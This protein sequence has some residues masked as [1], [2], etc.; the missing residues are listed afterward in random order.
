VR[1][2]LHFFAG[3]SL[4]LAAGWAVFPHVLYRVEPQPFE[5][6]HKIH[7]D[8]AGMAC[9]DC[10][11]FEAGGQFAG[12]PKLASC[13]TCHGGMQGKSAA[14]KTLVEQYVQPGREIPWRVYSRQPE[15]VR[16]SHIIHTQRAHLDCSRCHGT[17]GKTER[18][19]VY[20]ENRIT[21]ESR[22]MEMSACEDCHA[23]QR[24]NAGCLGCHR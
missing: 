12:I 23:K 17:Q 11:S 14:E 13:A 18:L 9:K 10:H 8:K 6:N 15:N 24:V 19:A 7:Q 21:G 1:T 16:F 22:D 4:S 2:A 3:V 5:F 20:S